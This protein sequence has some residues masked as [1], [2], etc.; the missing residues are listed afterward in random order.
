MPTILVVDDLVANR[1]VLTTLLGYK[2]Y[3][4]L[5]AAN[6]SEALA[7]IATD[8]P[9]LI[10]TDVLMPVMDGYE[11][12]RQLRAAPRTADIPVVFYTAHYGARDAR[13]LALSS[14]VAFVL[15]KP[16]EPE[17]V[18]RMIAV[19]LTGE[20]GTEAK[21]PLTS[22]F[23]RDHL[24]LITDKLSETTTDWR[25]ANTRLRSLINI[26]L[27]LA[28]QRD[29]SRLLESVRQ[30]AGEL[31]G[32][33]AISLGMVDR[34]TGC[35][36]H[37]IGDSDLPTAM[38]TPGP[39]P[40]GEVAAVMADRHLAHGRLGDPAGAGRYLIAPLSSPSFVYG[41]LRLE[42]NSGPAFDD[43]DEQL[44]MA[45]GGQV[46][47]IYENGYFYSIAQS[48]AEALQ[49]EEERMRFALESADIGI[50]DANYITG[51]L[52][53]SPLI[54]SQYGLPP[55]T[56][57]GTFDSFIARIHPDDRAQV[58]AIIENAQRT[59]EDFSMQHRTIW[60]DGSVH[61]LE[62]A[63]R[64]HLDGDGRPV[65]GLGIS[66]DVTERH[67][68]EDQYRQAQKMEAV[69]RLA[70]GVAHDFN[71]LLTA[72]LGHCELLLPTFSAGDSRCADVEEI[73]KSG[74]RAAALT[75]QLLAFSRKQIIEP[76]LL[77][78]GAVVADMR[79]MLERL[80]GED[81]VL[82]CTLAATPTVILAD[83]GQVEQ[84]VMNLV[85]NARDAM[86]SGGRLVIDTAPVNVDEDYAATDV[87]LKPG[88]FG[89]LTV[90]DSGT[91]ITPEVR[92]RLFEPFF[93]TKEPGKG[94]GL[95]LATVH[96]VTMRCGGSV[97]VYSEV[98]HGSSF[99]IFLPLAEGEIVQTI[100]SVVS[101]TPVVGAP[102]VLVVED[103]D[104][105]RQ[106]VKRLLE[107]QGYRVFVAANASEAVDIFDREPGLH[108]LLTDVV[109][110]G[111]SGPQ[112]T[113]QLINK[114]P[115]LK[116]VYMSGYTEDAIVDR[117]VLQPGVSFLQKPFTS[118][119]LGEKL[120]QALNQPT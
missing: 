3:R 71:N 115:E 105:L 52:K 104:G 5:E 8:R 23:S 119:A 100:A 43:D 18:L 24:R 51:S 107:R 101:A 70:G 85:V 72:I 118:A 40:H 120:R 98:G 48:R 96:G 113:Q 109:M 93:T 66:R 44:V 15:T 106:L 35:V 108:L 68:L 26:G 29:A 6:G 32:A 60:A 41:W 36:V 84:I 61:W 78:L 92:S 46:G 102:S 77:D 112:L 55:G 73:Q 63:G 37:A 22:E 57:D 79:P 58:L 56:F 11:L 14:G 16:A 34:A 91:G 89:V 47:R 74:H 69:G 62:G 1:Q 30:W 117:G 33:S 110:P 65:R 83:R 86:P 94:T 49:L 7:V 19:A 38:L 42:R 99:R 88:R 116:V 31:F 13:E 17:D 76:T 87:T 12:V 50:W 64:I 111:A 10:V 9:D 27:E 21:T 2:G 80:I 54:E 81:I 67:V 25:V 39:L 97:H 95:G 90:S 75:R 59:G 4:M 53:W 20:H 45:L 28:S 82:T 103:A 114:R